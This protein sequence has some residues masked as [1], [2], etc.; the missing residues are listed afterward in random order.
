M[1]KILL[2]KIRNQRF[3]IN[4]PFIFNIFVVYLL[5]KRVIM[6]EKEYKLLTRS[7]DTLKKV[8]TFSFELA[9]EFF[10]EIKKLKPIELLKIFKIEE[11]K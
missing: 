1:V 3:L 2:Y 10:S 9:I 11:V 7:G 8:R 5:N 6:N 4:F